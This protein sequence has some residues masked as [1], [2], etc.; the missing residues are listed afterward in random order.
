MVSIKLSFHLVI[1]A[2]IVAF[3]ILEWG[4]LKAVE[5]LLIDLQSHSLAHFEDLFDP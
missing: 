2:V 1:L 3:N 4:I 5:E